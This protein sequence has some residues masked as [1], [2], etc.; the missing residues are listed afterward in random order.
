VP[1]LQGCPQL[2]SGQSLECGLGLLH[3]VQARHAAVKQ[4]DRFVLAAGHIEQSR[5]L[6][7]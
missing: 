3:L 2:A 1:E 5:D 4:L 7:G 6:R